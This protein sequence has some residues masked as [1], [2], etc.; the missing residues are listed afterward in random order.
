MIPDSSS[1]CHAGLSPGLFFSALTGPLRKYSF[2][3]KCSYPGSV[4]TVLKHCHCCYFLLR[5][6]HFK[7]APCSRIE[8]PVRLTGWFS[9]I[10]PFWVEVYEAWGSTIFFQ[11]LLCINQ[12][13]S[14]RAVAV[15][16]NSCTVHLLTWQL[17]KTIWRLVENI[18][19]LLETIWHFPKTIWH[20][21]KT[22]GH[23]ARKNI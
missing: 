18:W 10:L 21:T 6:K 22:I 13:N 4:T 12:V 3:E 19:H 23:L 7:G 9:R 16:C 11:R 2:S 15:G 1:L 20:L 17:P 14:G 8:L 5:K